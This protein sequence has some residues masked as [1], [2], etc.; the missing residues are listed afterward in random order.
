MRLEFSGPFLNGLDGKRQSFPDALRQPGLAGPSSAPRCVRS[1]RDRS[2]GKDWRLLY[3][4]LF[5]NGPENSKRVVW[6][7]A[8]LSGPRRGRAV[9]TRAHAPRQVSKPKPLVTP[10]GGGR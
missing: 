4:I 10:L 9:V 7:E 6:V 3:F 5:K 2:P 8:V 1:Y